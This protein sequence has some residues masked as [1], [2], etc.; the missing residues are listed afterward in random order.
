[1]YAEIPRPETTEK[2]G[3]ATSTTHPL[4]NEFH[5]ETHIFLFADG[6]AAVTVQDEPRDDDYSLDP[7]RLSC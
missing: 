7:T 6:D 4:L 5:E 3:G 1:M 2:K